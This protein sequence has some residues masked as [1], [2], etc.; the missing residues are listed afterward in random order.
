MACMVA[1]DHALHV[2]RWQLHQHAHPLFG[3]RRYYP[4][5]PSAQARRVLRCATADQTNQDSPVRHQKAQSY[6]NRLQSNPAYQRFKAKTGQPPS[7]QSKPVQE[8]AN[9]SA[10]SSAPGSQPMS[11][12]QD[13]QLASTP[14]AQSP[15]SQQSQSPG[16]NQSI[17]F[18]PP[19][20]AGKPRPFLQPLSAQQPSP[21]AL[22]QPQSSPPRHADFAGVQQRQSATPASA[23]T[24][25][26]A[27][28]DFWLTF[29]AE[30]GQRLRVIG[31]HKNIG[32][33]Q[34]SACHTLCYS[35]RITADSCITA[36]LLQLLR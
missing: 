14:A 20:S 26:S 21:F 25:R 6:A 34:S 32:K 13:N 7:G 33:S 27:S 3:Q 22:S 18:R 23:S 5:L 12:P 9:K 15:S 31:S 10:S 8:A 29:H 4:R 30:F 19:S 28:V 11:L 16:R 24:S 35:T 2:N 36:A 17:T 1:S